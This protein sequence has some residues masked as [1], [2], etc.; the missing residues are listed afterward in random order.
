MALFAALIGRILFIAKKAEST[1]NL[2]SAYAAYGIALLIA[3]Q[4]FINVGV[5][6]GVLPTK[7]LTLPLLSYGGSS[8]ITVFIMLGLLLR[9]DSEINCKNAI[10]F[11]SIF[12]ASDWD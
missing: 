4:V 7:G 3:A 11:F 6:T 5:N 1:D 9:I 2:F 12:G 8:L 10:S